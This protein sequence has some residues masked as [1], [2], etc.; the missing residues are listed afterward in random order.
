MRD[1]E[2]D[3]EMPT[4]WRAEIEFMAALPNVQIERLPRGKL[5][6]HEEFP[7]EASVIRSFLFQGGGP[8]GPAVS[9]G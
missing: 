5:S 8:F 6:L 9:L 1:C 3:D 4:R 2:Q 7:D